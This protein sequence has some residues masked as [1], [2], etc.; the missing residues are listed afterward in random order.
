MSSF[1]RYALIVLAVLLVANL[2]VS[3]MTLYKKSKSK[4]GMD[5]LDPSLFGGFGALGASDGGFGASDGGFGGGNMND[6]VGKFDFAK[7]NMSDDGPSYQGSAMR[8]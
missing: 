4:E 7:N 8:E 1:E 5:D 2:V 3:S 6:F